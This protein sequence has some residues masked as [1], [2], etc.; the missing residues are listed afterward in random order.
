MQMGEDGHPFVQ[1]QTVREYA[2]MLN[3]IY[4]KANKR[5]STDHLILR[6]CEETSKIMEIARKDRIGVMP[7]QLARIYS[8]WNAFATRVGVDLHEALWRKYPGICTYC[9]KEENCV[10]GL[11][12]PKPPEERARIVR[13]YR[14]ERSREPVTL[15][16]HQ[17][18]HKKLY[19]HQNE[20]IMVIQTASHLC[21]E[22]GEVSEEYR[23]GNSDGV[24]DEMADVGSWLFSLSNR[25]GVVLA[26]VAWETY[27]YE[28][29]SCHERVCA[30]HCGEGGQRTNVSAREHHHTPYSSFAHHS[31]PFLED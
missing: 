18:L 16:D 26:R 5:Y 24:R 15:A 10:C 22:A 13:R 3:D 1:P 23:H 31:I 21:E 4:G 6:L 12:H 29:E 19:F 27:P 17:A 9:L 7:K 28:C 14:F 11:E 30:G 20:R 25:I 8:W 2:Q